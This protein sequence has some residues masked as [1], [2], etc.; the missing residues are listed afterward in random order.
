VGWLF[1]CLELSFKM[2]LSFCF[3]GFHSDPNK[4]TFNGECGIFCANY[5]NKKLIGSIME[6]FIVKIIY[7]FKKLSFSF[8]KG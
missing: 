8:L 5:N 6:R 7:P 1:L 4:C 2:S 3:N